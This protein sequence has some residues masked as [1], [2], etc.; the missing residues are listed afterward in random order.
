M[1]EDLGK[2]R[3]YRERLL[4]LGL[5]CFQVGHAGSHYFVNFKKVGGNVVG[6]VQGASLYT[7]VV[8][9]VLKVIEIEFI[10]NF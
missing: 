5:R 7:H 1:A 8:P 9:D 3:D 2:G 4:L 6:G 10:R